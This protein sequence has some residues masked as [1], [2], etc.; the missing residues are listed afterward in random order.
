[1]AQYFPRVCNKD[2]PIPGS[3]ITIKKGEQIVLP[4]RAIHHD[5]EYWPEPE[6]FDPERFSPENKAKRHRYAFLAFG[7]GP[8]NC[9]GMYFIT[10]FIKKIQLLKFIQ[11]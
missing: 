5:P 6:K 4:Y 7:E 1:M 2:Y 9:V 8:R 10:A 3:N 11:N